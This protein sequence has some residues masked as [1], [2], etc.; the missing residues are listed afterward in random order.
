MAQTK[1]SNKLN[2]AYAYCKSIVKKN[3]ENFPVASF[4]LPKY[5]SRAITAIYAFARTADN[6]ADSTQLTAEEKLAAL[7]QLETNFLHMV[8]NPQTFEAILIDSDKATISKCSEDNNKK[9]PGLEQDVSMLL[10]VTDTIHKHNLPITHFLDLLTAFKQDVSHNR[11]Y[12]FSEVLAYCNYSANP[13][14]RLLLSLANQNN[15]DNLECADYVCTSLQL[16]N[17]L[18]DLRHDL[19]KLDR[20]YIPL[21]ELHS[22]Q[23]SVEELKSMQP[24]T[25]INALIKHQLDRI[26][27]ILN[28]GLP[29]GSQL[30][31]LFGFEIRLIIA[32]GRQILKK[33]TM[34]ENYYQRP[35]LTIKDKIQ[36]LQLA[37]ITNSFNITKPI[38]VSK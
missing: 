25:K 27:T 23:V 37:L 4:F 26:Y 11:Y 14:G 15:I 32:G 22:F 12:D 10:A 1:N 8:K 33:L 19:I 24:S 28:K 20:C 3:Y 38:M 16:I 2:A 31:S 13:V 6:Y 36:M 30:N 29:L 21:K 5:L 9:K 17:F 35:T 34:R 18:Q 7:L